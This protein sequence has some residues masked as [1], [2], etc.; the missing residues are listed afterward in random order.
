MD[1]FPPF[2]PYF[3]NG[4]VMTM[5]GNFWKRPISEVAFPVETTYYQTEPYV[6]ILVHSQAPAC[7]RGLLILVH[8]LEGG[9]DS[10]YMRSMAFAALNAGF[11]VHRFH[12]RSCGG[13][14]HLAKTNYH[15]GQ[16]SDLLFVLKELRRKHDLP[17]WLVGYSLGGNVVLKLTGELGEDAGALIEGSVAVS[18]PLDLGE[19][20]TALKKRKNFLYDWRF[21]ERLKDRIRKRHEQDPELYSLEPMKR[22]RSV[23]DF[24]N[25]YTGPLF[26]FGD[27]NGYY[28]TQS[29]KNFLSK[30][31]VPTLV[32]HAK[33]DPLIPYHIYDHP[34]LASNPCIRFEPTEHGGHVGFI[35]RNQPRFWLDNR[36]VAWL[37]DQLVPTETIEGEQDRREARLK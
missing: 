27:A 30:I 33:D 20:A 22:V 9:S 7:P 12:M 1:P 18:T 6:Q 31:R 28:G 26:G 21:L 32:I 17:T 11:A 37:G 15:A 3:R 5:A 19:C 34:E 4:H 16:T 35:A 13:T 8:G 2:E 29:S 36:I 23:W 10:G 14:E 25:L 24:D